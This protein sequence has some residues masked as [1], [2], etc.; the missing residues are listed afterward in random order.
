MRIRIDESSVTLT[1]FGSLADPKPD[2]THV[3]GGKSWT[4]LM[5]KLLSHTSEQD[6]DKADGN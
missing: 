6:S 4:E 2:N 1:P 3:E 5:Q